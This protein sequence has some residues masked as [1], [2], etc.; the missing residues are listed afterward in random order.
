MAKLE[1][2][3]VEDIVALTPMQEGILFHYLKDPGSEEYFEQLS[4]E[5]EGDVDETLFAEAWR[6]VAEG[7]EM[8]RTMFRWEKV[9]APVQ[10]VLKA[11]PLRLQV[12][13]LEGI[14]ADKRREKLEAIRANDR[15]DKFDLRQVPFRIALCR[16]ENDRSEM[17]ISHHHILFDGWSTGLLLKQFIDAYR[18][19]GRSETVVFP[20]RKRFKDFVMT[21]QNQDKDEQ[22]RYWRRMF[23]RFETQARLASGDSG[24]GIAKSDVHYSVTLDKNKPE[25]FARRNEVTLAALVYAAW[26]I[27][28][29]KNAN[30]R[31]VVFGTTV[32]GR[33]AAIRGMEEVVGLFINTLPLR[34][35][36]DA[37]ES[38]AELV[39]KVHRSLLNREEHEHTPLADI[40]RHAGIDG[41]T[42]LF[43]TIVVFE[44]YP[45]DR[46][47]TAR[48]E[49]EDGIAFRSYAAFEMTN[50]DLTVS[51]TVS[52]G[53]EVTFS[54]KEHAFNASAVKRLAEQLT[55]V[56][57]DVADHPG[58]RVEEIELVSPAEKARILGEFNGMRTPFPERAAVSRLFEEQAARTPEL[59]AAVYNGRTVTYRELDAMSNSLAHELR[60][61]GVKSG[62]VVG[63][64]A[65]RSVETT[66][67]IIAV[68]KAGGA[69]LP[70]DPAY[71]ESRK[72]Y[73]LEDSGARLLLSR[74]GTLGEGG[75]SDEVDAAG[76]EAAG[77]LAADG[78]LLLDDPSLFAGN[79]S[80]L[81]ADPDPGGLFAVF[82]TS[83][84]TGKPKGVQVENRGVVNI[85]LWFG[86][87]YHIGS[88]MNVLQM[89]NVVFDPSIEEIFGTLLHGATLHIA[90]K[91]LILDPGQFADYVDRHHIHLINLVPTLL[92][93]LVGGR[94]R[95]DSLRTII[96]GGERLDDALKD[97]LTGMGYGLYNHYGPTETTVDA[98][99]TRCSERKVSLGRPIAN[100]RC[101]I[102]DCDGNL[103][104]TGVVGEICLAGAGVTR[105]YANS[106]ELTA[107]K[108]TDD[109]FV[110]GERMYRTGDLGRWS[111]DGEVELIGRADHQVKIRGYRIELG[112]IQNVLLKHDQIRDAVVI[113]RDGGN[114]KKS[115]CAYYVSDDEPEVATLRAFLSKKLPDFMVP[116]AYVRLERLPLTAVG[117]IDRGALPAPDPAAAGSGY[118]APRSETEAKL[119]GIW[120]SVLGVDEQTVGIH[121]NFFEL[122]GDSILSIQIAGKAMQAGMAITVSQMF[123]HQ[124]IAELVAAA[125]LTEAGHDGKRG[126]SEEE[127]SGEVPLT[128]IQRWFFEQKLENVHH[129]N[130]AVMLETRLGLKPEL[131][132]ESFRALTRAH[133]G[134]R[135]RFHRRG[136]QWI[137]SYAAV[138][139]DHLP[140]RVYDL[141]GMEPARREAQRKRICSALHRGLN[142]TDGPLAAA[143]YFENGNGQ[144]GTLF[145]AAHHLIVDGYSWRVIAGDIG[146]L[147]DQLERSGSAPPPPKSL[148]FKEWSEYAHA[149][150]ASSELLEKR[151]FWLDA[152][153]ATSR[154]IPVDFK[155]GVNAERDARTVSVALAKEETRRL[156]LDIHRPFGTRIDDI[157]LAALSCTLAGWSGETT[158]DLEG[159]G[160]EKLLEEHDLSRTV[161]WFTSVFPIVLGDGDVKGDEEDDGRPAGSTG[162]LIKRV[163]ERFRGIPRGGIGYEMLLY[164]AEE[165]VRAVFAARPRAQISF[166]YLG[167][168]DQ[169]FRN[170]ALFIK[171]AA[172]PGDTR[173]P[174]GIRSH[175]IDI[176]AILSDGELTVDWKYGSKIHEET[177]IKR[178]ADDFMRN[179]KAIIAYCRQAE[180]R[181]FTPSDFPLAPVTQ[182][183]LDEWSSRYRNMEDAFTL[184][185]VQQSMIFHHV[186]S[187]DSS[188]TVE[189]T[190]YTIKSALNI[191]AF[192][193]VWQT[194]L[195]RYESL[196]ASYHWEG[197]K[198]PVQL[199]H[200]G[201]DIPFEVLDWTD[202]AEA[203]RTGKLERWIESDRRLGFDLSKPPLMRITVV[204]WAESVYDVIWTHH[205]LQLDGW[206]VGILLGEIGTLYEAYCDGREAELP[207]ARPFKDYIAWFRGQDLQLAEQFWKRTLAG[208][209]TPVR[210]ADLFPSANGA[211]DRAQA[212]GKAEQDVSPELQ[213]RLR[214]F[215][216]KHHVTLNTIVQGAWALLLNRYAGET[217]IVFGTTSSGRPADLAGSGSMVGCFMNTLP[218]RVL[219]A[220]DAGTI[221]WLQDIQRSSVEMRQYEYTPLADIRS[222]SDA[223]RSSALYDLYESIVI[224]ENYPFDETLKDGLGSLRIESLRVEEQMDYPL[225]VYCNL[226]PELHFK[227]LFDCRYLREEEAERILGHLMNL[228]EGLLA[229]GEAAIGD[230]PMLSAAELRGLAHNGGAM[231][232][233]QERCWHELFEDRARLQPERTAVIQE[234]ER[235][236]Y[237]ELDLLSNRLANKLKTWGVGPD[238]PVGLYVERSIPMIVGMV[239]ILKAGGAF[240]PIDADYPGERVD[241]MLDDARVPV[242]LTESA[243]E[244]K[245]KGGGCRIV[246]LD[247]EGEALMREAGDRPVSEAKSENLA[248][249]IYTSGS[250]GRPKGVM[251]PHEAVVSHTVDIIGRYELTPEDRVLQFSSIGFDISLEQVLT[252]LAAGAA[253]VLRD[254]HTWT[255][256]EFSQKCEAYG[257]T[258][259]NLPTSY[260]NEVVQLWHS[261]PDIVPHGRLRLMVVGGERMLPERVAQWNRLPG[262]R[263]GLLNAYGPAETAMTSTLYSASSESSAADAERASTPVGKPLANRRIY[264]VDERMRPVPAGIKGEICIAG[265]PL[266]RG[267]LNN[268][269]LTE[270]KF[271]KDPFFGGYGS[272]LYRTG[273]LGRMLDDGNFE[274]LGR[275][276]E[277]T[278]IRGHRIEI[279]EIE[280][281][282]NRCEL[283]RSGVVVVKTSASAENDLA[284]FYVAS[285]TEGNDPSGIREFMRGSLPAYMVPSFIVPMDRLSLNPNG[286]IDRKALAALEMGVDPTEQYE[287]PENGIQAKLIAI[288]EQILGVGG[289]GIHH[290][291][292]ELGGQSLKAIKL[293]SEIQ[294][295]FAAEL[296]L[297]NV[298]EAPTIKQFSALIERTE[299]MRDG[300]PDEYAAA[301]IEVGP[302]GELAHLSDKR[303]LPAIEPAV[304]KERYG[305]SP[306]QR[307][308]FI[309][310]KLAG[311]TTSYNIP[312][313]VLLEGD[314][315]AARLERAFRALVERHEALRTSFEQEGDAIYQRIHRQAELKVSHL[316]AAESELERV[317]ERFVQPFDL[318]RAPLLRTALVKVTP[319]KWLLMYDMHHIVSDGLSVAILIRDFARLYAG[320]ILP[321]PPVRY[322]DYAEWQNGRLNAGEFRKQEEFWVREF[323]AE[324]PLLD[325]PTDRPRLQEATNEGGQ[326]RFELDGRLGSGLNALA[327]GQG[328]TLYAVLLAAFNI[329]LHKHSGQEDIVVGSPVAGRRSSDLDAVVGM[330]V[331]TVALRNFPEPGKSLGEF[332]KETA[333]RSLEALDRQD[334]PFEALVEKLQPDRALNRHPLF[335]VMFAFENVDLAQARV[336]GVDITPYEPEG[337]NAKFDLELKATEKNGGLRLVLEYRT[338]LF[339]RETI[340]RMAEHLISILE[341]MAA[342]LTVPIG[343]LELLTAEEKRLL[344]RLNETSVPYTKERT[345]KR[346][347][348]EQA[349][350]SA[351]RTAATSGRDALTYKALNEKANR[352][353]KRL[354]EAGAGPGKAFGILAEPSLDMIVGLWAA[355][356][357]GAAY[358]PV[359]PE[360][361]EERIRFMLVDSGVIGL[362]CQPHLQASADYRG[363]IIPLDQA[364]L[365][366]GDEENPAD[367]GSSDDPVYIVYTSGTT[368]VPKGVPVKHRSLINYCAWF[369]RTAAITAGDRTMLLSSFAFDLGY[370][371]LYSSLLNGGELHLAAKADYADPGKLL[372]MLRRRRISYIKLTP[373]LFGLLTGSPSFAEHADLVELRLVVLG[374]EELKPNDVLKFHSRFPNAALMNHY[375]PTETTIGAIARPITFDRGDAPLKGSIIGRPID[376]MKVFLLDARLKPV[377]VG[378]VGEICIAGDGLADGYLNETGPTA[379]KF[380]EAAV[381]GT[382]S[383]RLYRT[384]DLGRLTADGEIEFLGRA[385][386]QLKIRGYRVEPEEAAAVLRNH[387]SVADAAVIVRKTAQNDPILCAYVVPGEDADLVELRAYAA[388]R[389]PHYMV[390]AAMIRVDGIPLTPNG[391]IDAKALPDPSDAPGK[392]GGYEPPEGPVER[393]MAELWE[394]V[395]ERAGVGAQDSFFELGGHS[396]K[397][398]LLA[399][400][401]QRVFRVA[402]PLRD[403]FKAPTVRAMARYVTEAPE[404]IHSSLQPLPE[405]NVYEL[406][407]AQRRL[408]TLDQIEGIGTSYNMPRATLLEGKLDPDRLKRAFSEIVQRHE[409]FRTSFEIA[410]GEPVQRIHDHADVDIP[411][412][413][414]SEDADLD[415][416]RGL[417]GRA[418]R[419]FEA[420]IRPFDLGKAPLFR[421]GI[422]A[423]G[424]DRH[425]L[426]TDM[427]H[428]VSD[429]YSVGILVREF[430]KLYAGE[431]GELPEMTLQYKDFAAWQNGFVK[432]EAAERQLRYWAEK[433]SG[434]LPVLNLPTDFPRPALQSFEG[435]SIRFSAERGLRDRLERLARESGGTLYMVLL[436]AY[437]TLLS[438]LSA[439]QDLI[440]G[441]PVL[442]RTH[443]ELQ[444]IIGMFVS[445][446]AIRCRP[447]GDRT[448]AGLLAE[449][450]TSLLEAYDNQDVQFD[451]LLE[452]LQFKR[453]PGRNPVFGTMLALQE[454]PQNERNAGEMKLNPVSYGK[455]DSKFDL[456]LFA[457]P[458]E[459]GIHFEYEY[460]TKLFTQET[461]SKM[462]DDF[463]AVLDAVSRDPDIA[464]HDIEIGGLAD[465]RADMDNVT[466]HF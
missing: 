289:I 180:T 405:R 10:I 330:F 238:V 440:V 403:I 105:G 431:G 409:A 275:K 414:G 296:S 206:C 441:A 217:D 211:E 221:P 231:D 376:N 236:S 327:R 222:W 241:L 315:D 87:M 143:A 341:A 229:G 331:S 412:W 447:Q 278:K 52:D 22:Q 155:D 253:L 402:I 259:T 69:Y 230:I 359:D 96:S 170:D 139:G 141:S 228:I 396:L 325:L 27:V 459:S 338:E 48:R 158:V 456:S 66:A 252:T 438:K 112:E 142:L 419:L 183:K 157:L 81:S 149:Y 256:R 218:F 2:E 394:K 366:P 41:R 133:D 55:A 272:R 194:I 426:L 381:S 265:I 148:G 329:L 322:R 90:D 293:I 140:F 432:T 91:S 422:V 336:D 314:L 274:V 176:D 451:L 339:D 186:Y 425:V 34:V 410:D 115:L 345:I 108:F 365:P 249:I 213:Q 5:I 434:E 103:A 429:G 244:G 106:P 13:D 201:I 386:N 233:P 280:S 367:N 97:E 382:G 179:L 428:I 86:D 51:V 172:D 240:L 305:V 76:A 344:A 363:A 200:G 150:A 207:A 85:A 171:P 235:L 227:L 77:L 226:Q 9:K 70:L 418:E 38:A 15:A 401:I 145:I 107:E 35:S 260:W 245:V 304:E 18:R 169:L 460:A 114:G 185:P 62:D 337:S 311:A 198:E 324:I 246:C 388:S 167:Q 191:E 64:M 313:A 310:N 210:F 65:E 28:L 129:W 6:H 234:D 71:P 404:N 100:M 12:H 257:L 88:G 466:F 383:D 263:I 118:E 78:I 364:A 202:A 125:E 67:A 1:R 462:A 398:M 45:L 138:E 270:E 287:G 354:I 215:S 435:A 416:E 318:A 212:F 110:P 50:Y 370:T 455:R 271:G 80:P 119:A 193:R 83:G 53:I 282:L 173:D 152:A 427:H 433:L 464:L 161:G 290:H 188:V 39:R 127:A 192:R 25:E 239:A 94:R 407:S 408:Y 79:T 437:S 147:Y 72:Q 160:R 82:Y 20:A 175:L 132:R 360:F 415:P 30:A 361:P 89:T 187:P 374:G 371:S 223:P 377:P 298:F 116:S 369:T 57:E 309:V 84:T 295:E 190:V 93:Q 385:D 334:Y 417:T 98:L 387:G 411:Y 413:D 165:E 286:K 454:A 209:R 343:E 291:F 128:A 136:G 452:R 153:P 340:G 251:M 258:V 317:F 101:Y 357:S 335:D 135:L 68:L 102:L 184:S 36:R 266:A 349:E 378:A 347:L 262:G 137:Q 443:A 154:P 348:E 21:V 308:L 465:D 7:N 178:L 163:K 23:E 300:S 75:G 368:G 323:S 73:M 46:I 111:P 232:Y 54:C 279:G 321:A 292:F 216:R 43:D 448:F 126:A 373:S 303:T 301:A 283:V 219:T 346:L 224:F 423:L 400:D 316:R 159:H 353:A 281:V 355:I 342:D 19:L 328:V 350:K 189:Q 146:D 220:D 74:L 11:H 120:A 267:Y 199:I 32:S 113:D 151:G 247:T 461:M 95:L 449:V 446:L 307:R 177:T 109:P 420:F 104:P 391:K 56:M 63:I 393:R 17:I 375:G 356:K 273:D 121:D 406:S 156:L 124:T 37:G 269:G 47:V 442:G 248:Y 14:Q 351:G 444:S 397:A 42:D 61:R 58:K 205:H 197:L 8:L 122:G 237:A 168:F 250:T 457:Q 123:K 208:F 4:L 181:Q 243:L 288:W 312:G 92:K 390:P 268:P 99:F 24:P 424:K 302:A 421:V 254:K 284:A 255:P 162:T 242:L 320:E 225:T 44:N 264:I 306:A 204:K 29:Q 392:D 26:G 166:N 40:K 384:G 439:Q 389:L 453:D 195:S 277:Q 297:A 299:Q 285:G 144:N 203:E 332:V 214:Q 33:S 117:K 399:A 196:R 164:L 436:A 352:L 430:V 182:D 294:R 60:K 358:V 31:D 380:V 450:K 458:D 130:Q 326:V 333:A 362:L 174:D 276:D 134:F 379:G 395:L 49:S 16:L 319:V 131:L 445:T 261:A 372:E 59:A 463:L 3:L